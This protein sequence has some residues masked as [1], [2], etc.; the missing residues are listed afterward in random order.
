MYLSLRYFHNTF[1]LPKAIFSYHFGLSL[2]FLGW[3]SWG[4]EWRSGCSGGFY[5]CFRV[6]CFG[7]GYGFFGFLEL[8]LLF[9]LILF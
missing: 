9:F 5:W 8:L 3:F 2:F 7:L 1:L 6:S 4:G